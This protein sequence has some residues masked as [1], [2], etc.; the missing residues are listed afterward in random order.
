MALTSDD[1]NN[2]SECLREISSD[3]TEKQDF[4]TIS[5]SEIY[6]CVSLNLRVIDISVINNLDKFR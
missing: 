1:F 2:R 4:F 6:S 3:S 5:I